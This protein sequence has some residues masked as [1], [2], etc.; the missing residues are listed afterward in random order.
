MTEAIGS[1]SEVLKEG[2]AEEHTTPTLTTRPSIN[3][4]SSGD[5]SGWETSGT[6]A[7]SPSI[8]YHDQ[9]FEPSE[10]GEVDSAYED[11]ANSLTESLNSRVLNYRYE[12]GRR[13]HA[14][15]DGDLQHQAWNLSFNGKLH[16]APIPEDV[17]D[18]LDMATDDGE[19]EW[20]FDHKFDYIHGRA[21]LVGWRDWRKFFQQ[22]FD[23]LKPGGWIEC[24]EPSFPARCDDGTALPNEN[25]FLLWSKYVADG[26]RAHGVDAGIVQKFSDILQEIGFVDV[27]KEDRIWPL[28]PWPEDER[29]KRLGAI[30]NEDVKMGLSGASLRLFTQQLGWS[31]E[32]LE[33]FLVRVRR[34]V[35][36]PNQH[37]FCPITC[38]FATPAR[39]I[40]FPNIGLTYTEAAPRFQ[41]LHRTFRLQSCQVGFSLQ[42]RHDR[43]FPIPTRDSKVPG[44]N[45]NSTYKSNY[46]S[47]LTV[48]QLS[49][50]NQTEFNT[51]H[52][53]P[54][55]HRPRK[56]GCPAV[57][58]FDPITNDL[59]L[60]SQTK[61][62]AYLSRSGLTGLVILGSNA[63]AF[64]LTRTE[65]IALITCARAAV[66]RNY[67]LMVGCSGHSTK[68]VLENI[69]DAATAGADYALVLPA[70]YYG[71]PTTTPA[72]IK[73]FYDEI[74]TKSSL[75]IVIYNFPAVCNGI[76]LDSNIITSLA[77]SHPNKI[78]GVK[79]TCGSVAK[80]TRLTT[81]LSPKAFATF[82]G[83]SDFLIGGLAVGSA[84]CICA[85]GNVFPKTISTIYKLYIGGKRE[86]ALVL[87]RKAALAEQ[88][89]KPGVGATKYAAA[90]F[91]APRAGI[92]NV[93]EKLRMRRPY[94]TV[95]EEVKLRIREVMAEMEGIEKVL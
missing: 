16:L 9:T 87:H 68:Q 52:G 79:L 30:V 15:K 49:E 92:E 70:T 48:I 46:V 37:T 86:E 53:S 7:T 73:T 11:D 83:Q 51:L 26:S 17:Q 50:L 93:E 22:S 20:I 59:D 60:P 55:E 8:E 12:N 33:V 3:D 61:Y 94:G 13:Y 77:L 65:R 80:I 24:Q 74:A 6:D 14:L 81:A 72:V 34:D 91:S 76:D 41:D 71:K 31:R 47:I 28:N 38:R 64:L 66:P 69:T 95:G 78:V 18:V 85:F 45:K 62:F 32:Q 2:Q 42:L 43:Y 1:T 54:S 27:H 4:E 36:D 89:I 29:L 39:A 90:V 57:T 35:D 40:I 5:T 10:Y 23:H 63:E 67:P 25:A 44:D 58:F 75:P 56:W 82:G 84:G 21:M 19:D 88:G